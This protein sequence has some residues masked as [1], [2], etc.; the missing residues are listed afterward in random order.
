MC[1]ES[2]T[3]APWAHNSNGGQGRLED[4]V[5][6]L[7]SVDVTIPSC[8]GQS[9]RIPSYTEYY[10]GARLANGEPDKSISF[11]TGHDMVCTCPREPNLSMC[12][13]FRN[14][15][16]LLISGYRFGQRTRC[17]SLGRIPLGV[18]VSA[19]RPCSRLCPPVECRQLRQDKGPIDGCPSSGAS[20]PRR[21]FWAALSTA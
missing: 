7:H 20:S 19:P 5:V 15:C 12:S 14:N 13:Q 17:A 9:C 4:E 2:A 16:A 1:D 10:T 21:G 8:P 3:T 18:K 6:Q 11:P